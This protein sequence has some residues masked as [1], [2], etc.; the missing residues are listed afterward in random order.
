MTFAA[1]KISQQTRR[2][3]GAVLLITV[4]MLGAMLL[5]MGL[6][7]AHIGQTEIIIAGQMDRGQHALTRAVTC[8]EEA[9]YRLKRDSSYP[10]GS[11]DVGDVV[12]SVT[13]TGTGDSRTITSAASSDIYTKT[14]RVEASSLKNN[15]ANAEVWSIDSWQQVNP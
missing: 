9:L 6:S 2:Q 7:A 13:I 3:Q 1:I 11:I 4:I 8:V 12:C 10:G 14:I 5:I 15:D